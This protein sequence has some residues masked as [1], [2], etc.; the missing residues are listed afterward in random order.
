MARKK[1]SP[2]QIV[3]ILRQLEIAA[4]NSF[5]S[6]PVLSQRPSEGI[7]SQRTRCR[8]CLRRWERT[9]TVCRTSASCNRDP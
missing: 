1:H 6:L 7:W 2:E 3:A 8:N 4:A 9:D 5:K